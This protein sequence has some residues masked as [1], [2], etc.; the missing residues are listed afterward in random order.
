MHEATTH[1]VMP[2]TPLDRRRRVLVLR[3]QP[4]EKG[5]AEHQRNFD[6]EILG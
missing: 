6:D 5:N 2:W 3:Y 1:G 4:Q